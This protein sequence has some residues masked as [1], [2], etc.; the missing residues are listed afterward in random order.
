MMEEEDMENMTID[1][2]IKRPG[3]S[4]PEKI[5]IKNCKKVRSNN[6]WD[7]L[8]IC[9]NHNDHHES[10]AIN[11]TEKRFR[12]NVP[13]CGFAGVLWDEELA[14]PKKK[15]G[16]VVAYK[17]FDKAWIYYDKDGTSPLHRTC[18]II[19]PRKF[20]Q[21]CYDPV[22]K[23]WYMG[24]T[25]PNGKKVKLVLYNLKKIIDNPDKTILILEGEKSC[26]RFT[27]DLGLLVT[28]SPMG[29]GNWNPE[30]NI[31]LKGRKVVA[32]P[33]N[34]K[35]G[36]EHVIKIA[37]SNIR[38]CKSFKI[39]HFTG[40]KE[41][42]DSDDWLDKMEAIEFKGRKLTKEEILQELKSYI[43]YDEE[44]DPA[45]YEPKKF[46]EKASHPHGGK[47]EEEV[48]IITAGDFRPTDLW[49]SENFFQKYQG[50]LLYC[51]KWNSWLVY[52]EGK[53]QEDDK[54]ETQELAKK[55]VL[56][57]YREASEVIDDYEREKLVKH[58]LKSESQRAIRAMNELATSSMAVVPG[59]FDRNL[60]IFNLKNGT[61][62]LETVE[63]GEHKATD[64]LTKIAGVSYKPEAECPKWLA[65]L[66]M[67]FKGNNDLIN[68]MQTALGYSLTGDIGEQCWFILYGIGANGKTTFMNVVQ[69]I[70]GDYGI[71]TPFETFLSK[72]KFGGIPN[73]LAR[74]RG[75]RFI[76]ASEAGEN[77]KFDEELLKN[78]MGSDPIT[79]RFLR[80]EFF[81]FKPECKVWLASN[82]KPLVKQ[83]SSGF[84]RKVRLVPFKVVISE[85]ERILNY[86][87][88]LLKE[89]EGI[90]NWILGGYK[91]WKKEGLKTPEE[92]KEATAQ[93]RN[94]MDVL[95][96]FISECCIENYEA[97]IDTKTL[98]GRYCKWCN[99]NNETSLTKA[100][101]GRRLEER[102]CLPIRFGTPQKRGWKGIDLKD[103]NEELPY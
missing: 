5:T 42:E 103:Q 41:K 22:T 4:P 36:E 10:L 27:N 90:F 28:T 96:E 61:L 68:Y 25:L 46:K 6:G 67:I 64:M 92:V 55:V 52:R 101:F 93:Y 19:N 39:V 97:R 20:W 65:F 82:H 71:N 11:R 91:R 53:W 3:I 66:D 54:N 44:Y 31:Y 83:L 74:M 12:C 89:R 50:Q 37:D 23:K 85:E 88:I 21:E 29:A 33:D 99:E 75:A 98:Y 73:D 2:D 13:T 79:A 18:K 76:S 57:Y 58:S 45:K 7:L 15:K 86:D 17:K 51:K 100:S 49:N 47:K 95:I 59:G 62:D 94:Q 87:K 69:E 14:Y 35:P 24:L 8:G 80:Q 60:Y 26:D 48:R 43:D 30:F 34:D 1:I 78:M 81:D 63:F 102:G 16:A 70:L 38:N 9:P 40:L 32:I 72:G 84:W 56:D 77:R